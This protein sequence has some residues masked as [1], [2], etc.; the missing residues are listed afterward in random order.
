MTLTHG[1]IAIVTTGHKKNS[2]GISVVDSAIIRALKQR[3]QNRISVFAE[4]G[5]SARR[6]SKAENI[7]WKPRFRG[8]R[9]HFAHQNKSL[10]H[11]LGLSVLPNFKEPFLL[12]VHDLCSL[13]FKDEEPLPNWFDEALT[14]ASGIV[15]PSNF[16][17]NEIIDNFRFDSNRIH[18][19]PN[20]PGIVT[21][22][23]NH[24]VKASVKQ[25]PYLI[26]IGGYTKR[27]NIDWM[28]EIWP[29]I[30]AKFPELRLMLVGPS[31]S[32]S[33]GLINKFLTLPRVVNLG[34]PSNSTVISLLMSATALIFPSTYEGFGLPLVEA[35][36][37]GTPIIAKRTPISQEI[38]AEGALYVDTAQEVNENLGKILRDSDFRANLVSLGHERSNL[39]S[40]EKSA[41][42]LE[43]LYLEILQ[44]KGLFI[45]S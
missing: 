1:D 16:T 35:M 31:G 17:K 6:F 33:S 45:R 10:N 14:R 13:H 39:F 25:S 42:Q 26:R 15:T 5:L 4:G 2:G 27:K 41:E 18:V 40:W 22:N 44:E 20:G 28:L 8:M 34:N 3:M 37:L 24:D 43:N 30:A 9:L 32:D 29:E 23:I 19:I 21:L 38:C 36:K 12:T 11:Y 7:R